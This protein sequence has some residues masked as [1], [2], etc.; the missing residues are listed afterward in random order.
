MKPIYIAFLLL[1]AAAISAQ[2]PIDPLATSTVRTF[3][4]AELSPEAQAG[5]VGLTANTAL[6]DRHMPA[7]WRARLIESDV[8]ATTL[9]VV[10]PLP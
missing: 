4:L 2:Q 5:I 6:L 7:N 1:F 9:K 10:R 3:K 8:L